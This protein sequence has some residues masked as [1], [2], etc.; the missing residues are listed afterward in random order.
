MAEGTIGT[1]LMTLPDA[2]ADCVAC[3]F[4]K[5]SLNKGIRF[6]NASAIVSSAESV[7]TKDKGK[8]REPMGGIAPTTSIGIPVEGVNAGADTHIGHTTRFK[9]VV[10]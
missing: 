3:G 7:K 10:G 2:L 5:S 1:G 6:V 9:W 8:P 4:H